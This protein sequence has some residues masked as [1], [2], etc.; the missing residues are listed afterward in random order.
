MPCG[1]KDISI[2]T[3]I[4]RNIKLGTLEFT[5]WRNGRLANALVLGGKDGCHGS[6]ADS[7][8]AGQAHGAQLI[9]QELPG[10]GYPAVPMEKPG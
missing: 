9:W 7:S 10:G 5:P 2:V 6:L 8:V 1:E 4:G 3:N